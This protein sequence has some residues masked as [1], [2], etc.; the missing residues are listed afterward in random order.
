MDRRC[1]QF[2]GVCPR[3]QRAAEL[4]GRR[5]SAAVIRAAFEGPARFTEIRTAVPGLSA[6]LLAERLRELETAGVLERVERPETPGVVQYRLTSKGAALRR[7][8][9]ELQA[10]ADAWESRPPAEGTFEV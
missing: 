8:V 2:P 7:V 9:D 6:R 5:W 10:W 1:R 4:L 3:Y